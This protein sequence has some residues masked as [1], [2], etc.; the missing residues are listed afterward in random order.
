MKNYCHTGWQ[1]FSGLLATGLLAGCMTAPMDVAADKWGYMSKFTL[2]EIPVAVQAKLPVQKAVPGF[3]QVTLSMT[4]ES[5][6]TDG[7]KESWKSLATYKDG[8]HG[9]VQKML[10]L[11]SNDIVYAFIYSISYKGLLELRWQQVR[12]QGG[13]S[14]INETKEISRMH[15]I[16]G[17]LGKEFVIDFKTGINTQFLNY[18][19]QRLVCTPARQMPA[20]EIHPKLRGQATEINCQASKGEQGEIPLFRTKS[21]YLASYGFA[22]VLEE[23]TSTTKRTFRVLDVIGG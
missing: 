23:N 7:K 16:P 14:F 15:D 11:S 13:N 21:A 1:A 2:Q 8:G 9:T 5:E 12:L 20:T 18:T 10:E 19:P 6:S 17:E 3:S 22:I 4:G